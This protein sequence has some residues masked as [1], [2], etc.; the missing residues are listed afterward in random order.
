[1]ANLRHRQWRVCFLPLL[2]EFKGKDEHHYEHFTQVKAFVDSNLKTWRDWCKR[3]NNAGLEVLENMRV[4]VAETDPWFYMN[5]HENERLI[6]ALLDEH[7]L[8]R[9]RV[10]IKK[11]K[12]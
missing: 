12:P 11:V 1:M 9:I 10:R 5:P 4:E 2:P 8:T 6:E 3:Y 7:T